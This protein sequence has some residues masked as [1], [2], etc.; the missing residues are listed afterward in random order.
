[1]EF[2]FRLGFHLHVSREEYDW[3]AHHL[4]EQERARLPPAA[5][6]A[7]PG[8]CAPAESPP[9]GVWGGLGGD[10][11]AAA[12]PPGEMVA[13]VPSYSNVAE[14]SASFFALD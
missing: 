3:Y 11:A 1:V 12:S 4:R 2:L 13:K 6:A 9:A 8:P 14:A 5:A 10:C 7:S